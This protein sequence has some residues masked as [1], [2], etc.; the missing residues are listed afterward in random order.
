[1]HR[2]LEFSVRSLPLLSQPVSKNQG[3]DGQILN[4][5]LQY[6]CFS[7][8]KAPLPTRIPAAHT[9]D[10]AIIRMNCVAPGVIKTRFSS[11]LWQNEDMVS[12]LKKW[13]SIK[14]IGEPEEIGGVIAFLCTEEASY[15]TGETITVTGGMGCRL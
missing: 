5:I 2:V 8:R 1:M 12:E 3:G 10:S 4:S 7:R 11:A 15:I 14:R 13:L 6:H 9:A